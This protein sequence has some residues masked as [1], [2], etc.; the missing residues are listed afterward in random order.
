MECL[1]QLQATGV[2]IIVDLLHHTCFP[3]WLRRGFLDPQFVHAFQRYVQAFA[4]RYAWVTNYLIFNEPFATTLFSGAMGVWYPYR[5]GSR[6]FARMIVNVCKAICRIAKWLICHVPG[7]QLM[8]NDTCEFHKALDTTSVS[9]VNY[10]NVRRF[11]SYDLVLG[12]VTSLHPLYRYLKRRGIHEEELAF[13]QEHPARLNLLMLDYYAGHEQ[14]WGD[15]GI[16]E[17][18]SRDP[19]GFGSIALD[20]YDR[21]GLPL[22]VGETNIRGYIHERMT[23]AKFILEQCEQLRA[24]GVPIEEFHYYPLLDTRGWRALCRGDCQEI[25]PHGLIWLD[26][27]LN[28]HESD[29]SSNYKLLAE[30][31]I[32]SEHIVPYRF[33]K[34]RKT[35]LKGFLKLMKHW[36]NWRELY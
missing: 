3:L 21:Y 7:V 14:R 12:K 18:P 31:K 32:T 29:F 2:E 23:W 28:R 27:S 10:L 15:R 20:Y 8:F 36:T 19:R 34:A 4:R 9:W 26:R 16:W 6:S 33:Q 35:E 25:D 22:A 30:G 11:L 17:R 1:K 13:F 5:T 24:I